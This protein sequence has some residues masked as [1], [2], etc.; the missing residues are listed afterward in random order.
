METSQNFVQQASLTEEKTPD[1]FQKVLLFAF[2]FD[3][4]AEDVF[5]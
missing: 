2:Y 5:F 3:N 1:I 4:Q